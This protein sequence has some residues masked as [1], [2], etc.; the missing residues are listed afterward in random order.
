MLTLSFDLADATPND[1]NYLRSMFERFGWK[2]LGGSV[3]R[4][5]DENNDDWLNRVV[6]SI[7]F[8]RSFIVERDIHLKFFTID[9]NSTS[10]LDHSDEAIPLGVPPETGAGVQLEEPTNN[11]SSVG[12]IRDFIDAASNATR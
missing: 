11:Q 5:K 3:F 4:Y 2:R 12:T 1:R 8:F 7:M 6:P 9:A 10:F